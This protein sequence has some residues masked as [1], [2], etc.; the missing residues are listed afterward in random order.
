MKGYGGYPTMTDRESKEAWDARSL[1]ANVMR[2]TTWA[3][4]IVGE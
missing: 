1:V 3:L 2:Q 4:Q